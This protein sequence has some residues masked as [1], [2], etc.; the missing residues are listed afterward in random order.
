MWTVF[1]LLENG[2]SHLQGKTREMDLGL[3]VRCHDGTHRVD[4]PH[5]EPSAIEPLCG[6]EVMQISDNNGDGE[7]V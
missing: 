6:L 7:S 2:I 1:A 5:W 4:A 3:C